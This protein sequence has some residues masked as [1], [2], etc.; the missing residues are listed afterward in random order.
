MWI[1]VLAA[2]VPPADRA[3]ER[4]AGGAGPHPERPAGPGRAHAVA[5]A[6][7]VPPDL[8]VRHRQVHDRLGLVVLPVLVPGRAGRP[9]QGGPEVDRAADDHRLPAGRRRV[10]RRGVAELA[11]C[12]AAGGRP[13]RRARRRCSCARCAS[14]RWSCAPITDN[15]WVAVWLVGVAAAAHQGFSANLFTLT[16]DM[17]PRKAVGSVVGIGGFFGAIGGFFLNMA[18][19]RIRDMFG[20]YVIVFVIAGLCVPGGAAGHPP[21]GA[22]AGA[23]ADSTTRIRGF[24]V[25]PR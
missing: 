14:C 20:S 11:R 16:S 7:P 6:A 25:I 22:A 5:A 23:G 13:T 8:G 12:S 19:G 10:D 21:A 2:A 4:L 15:Q 1:V 9:V 24:P 3:P 17:F 18:A